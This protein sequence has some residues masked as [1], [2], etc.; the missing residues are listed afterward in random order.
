LRRAGAKVAAVFLKKNPV[1]GSHVI[2]VTVDMSIDGVSAS[3][4]DCIALPGGMPG[5][6]NLKKDPRVIALI[7]EMAAAGKITAAL[8][9]APM[10]L[11][12]AGVLDGKRA[13]CYP[14]FEGTMTGARH[15][16]EPV[17]RDGSIITGRGPG[18]GIPFALELVAALSGKGAADGVK[19]SM[20][21]Y[22]M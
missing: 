16:S 19:E 15:V 20:Q 13:T 14:G 17:V 8:C 7:R 9:A 4:Y 10:V 1:I 22:W 6:E 5:S 18:C 2:S 3:E 12:A 11:G 21:V